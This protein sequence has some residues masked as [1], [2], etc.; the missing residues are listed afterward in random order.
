MYLAA[1]VVAD[2]LLRGE[3]LVRGVGR[4]CFAI[5]GHGRRGHGQRV[6]QAPDGGRPC[7]EP[8]ELGPC[9]PNAVLGTALDGE[10][11]Q[12]WLKGLL[13]V[14][15]HF[16]LP[17]AE[18]LNAPELDLGRSQVNRLRGAR[19]VPSASPCAVGV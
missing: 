2:Q 17:A 5:H 3:R 8:L 19:T 18:Q 6:A 14:E 10:P 4:G 7:E 15:E 13:V 1:I 12:L 16:G 11:V 9:G